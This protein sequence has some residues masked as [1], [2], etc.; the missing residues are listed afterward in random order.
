MVQSAGLLRIAAVAARLDC[1]R[2][3]VYRLI[4]EGRLRAVK[5]GADMR[6]ASDELERYVESLKQKPA[7][8]KGKK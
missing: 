8:E 3:T 4:R 7:S 6:I 1:S 2:D 5:L